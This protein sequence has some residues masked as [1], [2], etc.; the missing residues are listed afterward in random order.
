MHEWPLVHTAPLQEHV[1]V[2]H[3]FG[4]AHA[5]WQHTLSMQWPFAHWLL[6]LQA[7]P[8]VILARQVPES[9][10]YPLAQSPLPPQL[11]LHVAGPHAYLPQ[12]AVVALH[13][14]SPLQALSVSLPPVQVEAPHDVVVPG[15]LHAPLPSHLPAHVSPADV[16]LPRHSP[17]GSVPEA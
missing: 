9:H 17:S 5:V 14:P 16:A 11:V 15:N 8:S 7:L 6:P 2:A 3:V 12:D 1:P 10:Q 13:A 4:A